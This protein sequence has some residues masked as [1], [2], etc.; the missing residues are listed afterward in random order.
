MVMKQNKYAI[1]TYK[2]CTRKYNKSTEQSTENYLEENKT[3]MNPWLRE[4]ISMCDFVYLLVYQYKIIL[5]ISWPKIIS[6]IIPGIHFYVFYCIQGD[7]SL[8]NM[9]CARMIHN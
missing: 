8:I 9:S 6:K 3:W 1:K 4:Y 2:K 7:E 5:R